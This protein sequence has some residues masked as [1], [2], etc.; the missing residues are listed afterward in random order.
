MKKRF[1]ICVAAI[2]MLVLFVIVIAVAVLCVPPLMLAY[3]IGG[4]EWIYKRVGAFGQGLDQAANVP[5]MDGHPKETISSHAGRYFEAVYG[6]P[7]KGRIVPSN[8]TV[9]IPWQAKF[10]KWLTDLAEKDHVLHAVEQWA[11][12][13]RVPL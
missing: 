9:V 7:F 12:D 4:S 8:P 13:D 5:F 1:G 2:V 6:N 10:V 11:V 3:F